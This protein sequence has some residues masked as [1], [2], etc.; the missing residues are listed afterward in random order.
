MTDKKFAEFIT[1]NNLIDVVAD[2]NPGDPPRTYARGTKRL[3]YILCDHRIRQAVIKSGSLALHD[4][5]F[6]DHTMQWVDFDQDILFGDETADR[7]P[8]PSR[9]FTMMQA[10]KKKDFQDKLEKLDNEHRIKDRVLELERDFARLSN[11]ELTSKEMIDLVKRYHVLDDRIRRNMIEAADSVG[12]TDFGYQRSHELVQAG[13]LI[14]FWK[15]VCSC[16]RR[17]SGF[18]DRLHQ[19]GLNLGIDKQEYMSISQKKARNMAHRAR[20]VKKEIHKRDGEARAEWLEEHAK[21]HA[22]DDPHGTD[23]KTILARMISAAKQKIMQKRITRIFKPAHV[24]LDYIQIPVG[25]WF[26]DRA[27]DEVYEF[28]QGLF[29]AHPRLR[30]GADLTYSKAYSLK[31]MPDNVKVIEISEHDDMIQCLTTRPTEAPQWQNV[32]DSKEIEKWLARRNKRHYQQVWQEKAYPTQQPLIGIFGDH[33]TTQEV[34]DL[35]EG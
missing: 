34:D 2:T 21:A 10:R 35:L 18:T 28:D 11:V 12:R 22:E 16:M 25:K 3:D 6:S 32:T 5:I 20:T 9:Q 33:G 7:V 13:R 23:W 19:L 15:T 17:G 24:P 31:T 29:R 4:G 26:Y 1:A 27:N 8:P 30:G 14:T